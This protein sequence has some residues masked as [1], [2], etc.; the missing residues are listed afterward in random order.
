MDV[1][2]LELMEYT[3]GEREWWKEWFESAG[4][5]ALQV[6]TGG[7]RHRTVADLIQH[8][9]GTEKRYIQRMT[10]QPITPINQIPKDTAEELFDFGVESRMAMRDYVQD[11]KDWSR[12]FEFQVLDI[13]VKASVRKFILHM[14]IHEIRHWAQLAV[15]LRLGG[16]EELGSHDFL[17][18]D[19]ML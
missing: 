6:S 15:Y 8:I 7:E 11:V 10:G 1:K 17:E 5:N 19:A 2:I 13:H 16:Y 3:K 14:L 9:F 12:M 4:D 18:S